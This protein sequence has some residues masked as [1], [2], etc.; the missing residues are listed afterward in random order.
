M[1]TTPITIEQLRKLFSSLG[2]DVSPYT[3]ENLWAV[4]GELLAT[5]ESFN[6]DDV[7]AAFERLRKFGKPPD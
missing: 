1:H 5:Q 4:L 3:D 7:R 6:V 2:H